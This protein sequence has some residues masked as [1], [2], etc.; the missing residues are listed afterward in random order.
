ME[1]HPI[2]SQADNEIDKLVKPGE[3]RVGEGLNEAELRHGFD[4]LRDLRLHDDL[5]VLVE[6]KVPVPAGDQLTIESEILAGNWRRRTCED[7]HIV[8][9]WERWTRA[10]R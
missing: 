10:G 5:Q 2:P 7:G 4:L 3:V 9:G 6:P 8:P 1:Y